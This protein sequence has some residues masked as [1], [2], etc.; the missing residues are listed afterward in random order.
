MLV[1]A[2]LLTGCATAPPTDTQQ[3]ASDILQGNSARQS[4]VP[5]EVP[6]CA[7]AGSRIHSRKL[8]THCGCIP[9]EDIRLRVP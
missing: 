3:I 9:G 5:G 7:T 2:G 6:Y 1:V 4:C 8:D